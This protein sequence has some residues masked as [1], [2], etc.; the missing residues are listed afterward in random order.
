MV[1]R[2]SAIS[3][4]SFSMVFIQPGEMELTFILYLASALPLN[5]IYQSNQSINQSI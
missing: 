5:Q 2:A 1:A 3:S 4:A